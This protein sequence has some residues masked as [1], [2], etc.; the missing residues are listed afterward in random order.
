MDADRVADAETSPS[1]LF[2]VFALGQQVR[3]LLVEAM[4][5][6]PL[7][8]QDYAFLSAVFEDEAPT[9]TQLARR[10]GMPLSTTVEQVQMFEQRGYLRRFPNPRDGRSYLVA[11]T[12]GGGRAHRAAAVEFD[13]VYAAVVRGLGRSEP[14][15]ARALRQLR[16]AVRQAQIA[17]TQVSDLRR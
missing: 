8:P 9:P 3:Q 6:S 5:D 13:R 4:R 10:L 12:A 16:G 15:V 14:A 2:E 17:Q 1:I 11:L 7:N